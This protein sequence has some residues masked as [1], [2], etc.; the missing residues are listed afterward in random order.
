MFFNTLAAFSLGTTL[1]VVSPVS[2]VSYEAVHPLENGS[3]NEVIVNDASGIFTGIMG[4]AGVNFDVDIF[5]DMLKFNGTVYLNSQ[6]DFSQEI[7]YTFDTRIGYVRLGFRNVISELSGKSDINEKLD[8]CG[9]LVSYDN[10][11]FFDI[12]LLGGWNYYT[13]CE[14]LSYDADFSNTTIVCID[15]EFYYRTKKLLPG[16]KVYLGFGIINWQYLPDGSRTF[17]PIRIRYSWK[18]GIDFPELQ[19][20][21]GALQPEIAFAYFCEHAVVPNLKKNASANEA[22]NIKYSVFNTGFVKIDCGI[23]VKFKT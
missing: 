20:K 11:R 4:D 1:A 5:D 14:Y 9:F 13:H 19:V 6:R 2:S 7:G 23:K 18:A 15:P 17:S 8:Y 22:E 21:R 12:G 16:S 10:H 3:K